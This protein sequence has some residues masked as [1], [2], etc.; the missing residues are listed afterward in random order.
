MSGIL[1][2]EWSIAARSVFDC[3]HSRPTVCVKNHMSGPGPPSPTPGPGPITVPDAV[4]EGD[5]PMSEF[6]L[7]ALA[8][9]DLITRIV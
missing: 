9:A 5:T 6:E 7:S 3:G 1:A 8:F 2:S 4:P